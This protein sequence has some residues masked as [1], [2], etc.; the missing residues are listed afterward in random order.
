MRKRRRNERTEKERTLRKTKRKEKDDLATRLKVTA[1]T[2]HEN[3]ADC[4][5]AGC[6]FIYTI[7]VQNFLK[8]ILT[9]HCEVLY[10]TQEKQ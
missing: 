9:F 3:E 8:I 4:Y 2:G 10:F 7:N 6:L 1:P 5:A